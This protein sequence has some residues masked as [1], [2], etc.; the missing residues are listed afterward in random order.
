MA[1]TEHLI[2]ATPEDV[3]AVLADGWTYSDWVVG[4]AHIRDVDEG[5]PAPGSRIH[6]KAGPWPLSIHESTVSLICEPPTR[7]VMRPRLWPF[8]EVTVHITLDDVGEHT[9]IVI[10]EQFSG[11]PLLVLRNQLNDMVLGRR[12]RESLRRLGDVVERSGEP[13]VA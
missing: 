9:R 1:R 3:F 7:L 4:T 6:H 13:R 11:G 8:G 12:N 2:A 5:W 10:E